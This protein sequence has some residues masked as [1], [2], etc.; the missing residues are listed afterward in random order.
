MKKVFLSLF[1]F[2]S[3]STWA[4]DINAM[5][6]HLAS[7]KQV[8]CYLSEQ[9][10][11]TFKDN[12]IVLTTHM[13]VVSYREDDILKF[14]YVYDPAGIDGVKIP[15]SSISFNGNQ[16]SVSAL[17]ANSVVSVFSLDGTLVS[18]ALTDNNGCVSIVL[19]DD[20]N[21]VY[22]VKTSIATFKIMK[23]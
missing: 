12:E 4:E 9:P 18:S 15:Q 14:T 22:V 8:V 21:T 11:V 3:L 5:L 1:A 23:P 17:D 13:N 19:P 16:F 6:L 2:C 10:N 7:G 20:T